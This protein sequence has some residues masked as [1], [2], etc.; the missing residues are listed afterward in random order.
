MF[1]LSLSFCVSDILDGKVDIEDV[2]GIVSGTS[3]TH[4]GSM[5]RVVSVYAHSYWEG[6]TYDE[7]A[8]VL[9]VL[10][11]GDKLFQPRIMDKHVQMDCSGEK[12]VDTLGEALAKIIAHGQPIVAVQEFDPAL[13]W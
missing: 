9:G 12:W 3:I 2:E 7:I 13:V 11:N 5:Y 4:R 8:T 1:G 6:H 10:I